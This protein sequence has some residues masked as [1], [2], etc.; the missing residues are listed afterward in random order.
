MDKPNETGAPEPA[1]RPTVE[2]QQREITDLRRQ[3]STAHKNIAASLLTLIDM[4]NPQLSAHSRRVARW[5]REL[6]ALCALR[7]AELD[8]LE[9][10]AVLHD[11]GLLSQPLRSLRRN[12]DPRTL[13]EKMVRHPAVGYS[14]LQRIEGFSRIADAVLHHHEHFDGSGYPHKMWGEHIPLYSRIIAVADY[15]ELELRSRGS[16]IMADPEEAKR[17]LLR[18]R[19]KALDPELINKFLYVLASGDA[20]HRGDEREVEIP[21]GALKPGMVLSRDLRS[22]DKVLL[23][24]AG[25]ILTDEI[26]DRLFASDKSDW[27]VGM[28]HVDPGSI[29]DEEGGESR[30]ESAAPTVSAVP[31]QGPAPATVQRPEIL[32][33][34]DSAAVCSALRRELGVAG[35]NV[36]GATTVPEALE[37]LNRRRFD[38]VITDIVLT[39]AS[40]F[41]LLRQL[42]D[43][44]PRLHA[45]VVS[46]F[47]T[48]D[49][50][51]AL[52]EFKNVVRFVTKPWNQEVLL[53]AL[54]EAVDRARAG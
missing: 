48:A 53:A 43:Q 27:L 5:A 32:V 28:V 4:I 2:S 44:H 10:A 22:L 41:E 39:G 31:L 11:L 6:G 19:G 54:R 34:D 29:R 46:G 7:E 47:P 23:L 38:A 8:E 51:R 36:T 40:G 12:V 30:R 15:Y 26:I 13:E 17:M 9:I 16:A 50:I 49:N 21:P 20:A 24:K 35:M 25:T 33:V 18:E 52:R 1:G 45:V 14:L 3:V 37:Q 42:R